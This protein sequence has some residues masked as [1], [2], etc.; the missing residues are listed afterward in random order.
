M[1]LDLLSKELER[2]SLPHHSEMLG[3]AFEYAY[4]DE[5]LSGTVGSIGYGTEG[6]YIRVD[7]PTFRGAPI[8]K[9]LLIEINSGI[10]ITHGN[11]EYVGSITFPS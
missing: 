4:D 11:D 2:L 9:I 5:R 8:L 10:L 7:C 3:R 1:T 6:L